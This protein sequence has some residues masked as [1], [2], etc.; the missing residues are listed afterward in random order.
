MCKSEDD[1]VTKVRTVNISV[2]APYQEE[3]AC[4]RGLSAAKNITSE[5]RH[6]MPHGTAR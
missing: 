5:R 3:E 6:L 2:A 4:P 1:R